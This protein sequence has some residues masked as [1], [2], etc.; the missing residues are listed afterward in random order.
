MQAR[1]GSLH[2]ITIMRCNCADSAPSE[3]GNEA[4]STGID[5]V[6]P[7]ADEVARL[8]EN[9]R[10]GVVIHCVSALPDS[11]KGEAQTMTKLGDELGFKSLGVVTSEFHMHRSL[12]WFDRC[13]DAEVHAVAVPGTTRG[14]TN[15]NELLSSAHALVIDRACSRG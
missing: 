13:T 7:A 14:V 12:R 6:S 11:T 8:C 4:L 1:A 10:V 9:G 2:N 5:W 3:A 15:V